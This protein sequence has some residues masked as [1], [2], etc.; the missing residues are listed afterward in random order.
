MP[1]VIRVAGNRWLL[2]KDL[3]VYAREYERAGFQGGLNWYRSFLS[4]KAELELFF[5]LTIDQPSIFIAGGRCVGN[6]AK[7]RLYQRAGYSHG[8]RRVAEM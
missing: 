8:A 7:Q 5:G 4:G 2:D 1:S 6:D 3:A